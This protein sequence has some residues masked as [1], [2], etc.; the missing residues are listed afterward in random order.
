MLDE[1]D[2]VYATW[3]QVVVSNQKQNVQQQGQK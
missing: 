1:V 3:R 2:G